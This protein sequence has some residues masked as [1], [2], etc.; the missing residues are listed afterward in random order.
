MISTDYIK[1][2]IRIGGIVILFLLVFAGLIGIDRCQEKKDLIPQ[3]ILRIDTLYLH[4][5]IRI[6]K[7]IPQLIKTIDTFLVAITDTL[8]IKDTVYL[9]LPREQKTYREENFHAWVSGYRP[10]LDSIHIFQNT[11]Q[12]ITS[13]TV[14]QRTPRTRRWGIGIQAGYGFTC[15]QNTIQSIPYVGIGLSYTI[16]FF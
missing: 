10:A 16:L 5:T 8:R 6:E 1:L 14:Q 15:Q 3:T 13:S 12:I 4:D 7:P 11:H 2:Y 9:N